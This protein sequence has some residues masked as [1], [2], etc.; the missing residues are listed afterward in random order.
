MGSGRD[1]VQEPLRQQA[2]G[3]RGAGQPQHPR[4]AVQELNH[5]QEV[6]GAGTGQ[7]R[8]GETGQ[9]REALRRREVRD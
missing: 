9:L 6:R 3:R 8:A 5:H 2:E 4:E 7:E 1:P